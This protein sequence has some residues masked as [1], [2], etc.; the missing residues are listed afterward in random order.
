MYAFPRSPKSN[1]LWWGPESY[2]LIRLLDN[3][4]TSVWGLE[5]PFHSSADYKT[6]GLLGS[7]CMELS[8]SWFGGGSFASLCVCNVW[9]KYLCPVSCS[10][11]GICI[12][13]EIMLGGGALGGNTVMRILNGIGTSQ[14]ARCVFSALRQGEFGNLETERETLGNLRCC[15]GLQDQVPTSL[16]QCC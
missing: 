5:V 3:L 8:R 10:N 1:S 11:N 14:R 9:S 7:Q 2:N 15:S 12:P 6:C 16:P 4:Y 13:S